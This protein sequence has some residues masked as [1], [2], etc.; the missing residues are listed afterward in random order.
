MAIVGLFSATATHSL[1][2][3]L[4]ANGIPQSILSF[5]PLDILPLYAH[6]GRHSVPIVSR[7]LWHENIRIT[8]D[9]YGHLLPGQ[10]EAAAAAMDRLT[11]LWQ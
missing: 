11:A 9:L 5:T 3:Y 1:P 2:S 6:P 10:D 7:R 4:R 8:L